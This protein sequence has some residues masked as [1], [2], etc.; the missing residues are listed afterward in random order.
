MGDK[1]YE[2]IRI[3]VID[4]SQEDEIDLIQ[5]STEGMNIPVEEETAVVNFDYRYAFNKPSINEVVLVDNKQ[6]EDLYIFPLTNAELEEIIDWE[7][8]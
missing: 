5:E 4:E 6:L 3:P 1:V 8:W 2:E 7:S